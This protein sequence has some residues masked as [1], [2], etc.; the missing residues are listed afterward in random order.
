M[1]DLSSVREQWKGELIVSCQAAPGEPLYGH[2]DALARAAQAGGAAG[3]RADGP[4]NIRAIRAVTALPVVASYKTREKGSDVYVTP[5]FESARE[6]VAAGADVVGMD[7][8]GR[9][10]PGGE[11]AAMMMKRV[12]EEL[13]AGV[14]ADVSTV[15][16]AA[17]AEEAGADFVTTALAGFTSCTEHIRC[18]DFTLLEAMVERLTVPVV[19]EGWIATPEEAA[20]ALS[21]GA[22]AIVVGSAITRPEKITE[23]FVRAIRGAR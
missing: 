4:E 2:V 1:R 22:F 23:R 16:E 12:H 6:I 21:A 20:A 19:A 5:T 10:R 7:A 3:I 14:M 13:G 18:F 8:T 11:E 9:H 17:A 15:E